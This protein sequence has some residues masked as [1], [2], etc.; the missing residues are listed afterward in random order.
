MVRSEAMIVI[1]PR[2]VS[3]WLNGK[4]YK[5]I[6]IFYKS[7]RLL[8]IVRSSFFRSRHDKCKICNVPNI[9]LLP[10]RTRTDK[11]PA[12]ETLDREKIVMYYEDVFKAMSNNNPTTDLASMLL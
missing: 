2:I 4:D 7:L 10:D 5:I 11:A 6:Y 9:E 3:F 1:H 12:R 8:L